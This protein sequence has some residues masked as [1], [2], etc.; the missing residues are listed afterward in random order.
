MDWLDDIGSWFS[1]SAD[2]VGDWFSDTAS[3][4]GDWFSPDP[5]GLGYGDMVGPPSWLAASTASPQKFGFGSSSDW[6]SQLPAD[7]WFSNETS[8]YAFNYDEIVP[9]EILDIKFP[10]TDVGEYGPPSWL[11]NVT[12]AVSAPQSSG[13][14]GIED[15][16]D[17][18]EGALGKYKNTLGLGAGLLGAGIGFMD[19]RNANKRNAKAAKQLA[20]EAAAR[21]AQAMM[22]DA[23]LRSTNTR[24]PNLVWGAKNPVAFNNNAVNKIVAAAEGGHIQGFSKGGYAHGGT[25]GQSDQI[26]AMLSDGEFVVDAATV[27]DLGDGNNAAG[28]SALERMRQNVRKHKRSAPVNKIPP[29]AKKPEQYMK[30]GK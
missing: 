27:A 2:E 15:F 23:P 11:A 7:S 13:G 17:K 3:D 26:P 1:E 20:A 10:A 9:Q 24:T 5:V 21:R 22:Y 8:P 29:K 14:G 16:L 25:P 12:E 19:A 18:T 28:A 4:V 30:K 6:L